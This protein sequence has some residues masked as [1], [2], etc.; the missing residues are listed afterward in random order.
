MA[1]VRRV[2]LGALAAL[3]VSSSMGNIIGETFCSCSPASYTF[4]FN[5]SATCESSTLVT[6]LPGLNETGCLLSGGGENGTNTAPVSLAS[7]LIADLDRDLESILAGIQSNVSSSDTIVYD[8]FTSSA[9]VSA[10]TASDVPRGLALIMTGFNAL[11]DSVQMSIALIFNPDCDVFPVISPG[12]TVGWLV[13]VSP[14]SSRVQNLCCSH[15]PC[16]VRGN[17]TAYRVLSFC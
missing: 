3:F 11:G 15:Q 4:T 7:V 9:N 13:V 2:L 16:A 6:G 17:T 5:F 1:F 14:S 12:D 10:T 8:T